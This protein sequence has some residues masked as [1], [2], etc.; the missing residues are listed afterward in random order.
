MKDLL[1]KQNIIKIVN[2]NFTNLNTVHKNLLIIYIN[3]VLIYLKES[4]FY[5]N[6]NKDDF[7]DQINLDENRDILGIIVL[8]LPYIKLEECYKITDLNEL[9]YNKNNFYENNKSV[10]CTYYIDHSN[11][12]NYLNNIENMD[13]DNI[14]KTKCELIKNTILQVKNKLMFNWLNIFPYKL[15]DYKES[16]LYKNFSILYDKKQ[17]NHV[18]SDNFI[19]GYTNLYDSIL[20]FMYNQIK[21]IKFLIYDIKSDNDFYPLIILLSD[22]LGI[23]NIINESTFTL[24]K[25]ENKLKLDKLNQNWINFKNN[26]NYIN[27]HRSLIFF[28]L[29][30]LNNELLNDKDKKREIEK[31]IPTI[32]DDIECKRILIR[33][34]V[35][36]IDENMNNSE[37]GLIYGNVDINK[38]N[39]CI[40]KIINNIDFLEI[41]EY[42]YKCMQQFKYTW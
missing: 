28:Y 23:E 10:E 37:D 19:L 33:E 32:I 8:I 3:E 4:F 38:I 13:I 16:N 41:Y 40:E 42:L 11:Y 22:S 26:K 9:Y 17:F 21:S 27:I 20:N 36:F 7:L 15:E 29:R 34:T 1:I 25:E 39:Y 31:N 2:K 18:K 12:F 24:E 30:G 35:K 5:E 6:F 14:L